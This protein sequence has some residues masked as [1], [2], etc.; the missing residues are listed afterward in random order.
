MP[1]KEEK[2]EEEKKCQE[3]K[4]GLLQTCKVRKGEEIS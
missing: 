4:A 3:A 1:T 2:E